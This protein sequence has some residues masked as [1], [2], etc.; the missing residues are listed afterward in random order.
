MSNPINV[1][2]NSA[3]SDLIIDSIE[4]MCSLWPDSLR[5]V[6]GFD[7]YLLGTE[8]GR[9]VFFKA[10]GFEEA[11]PA[12][13]NSGF[14]TILIALDNTDGLPQRK[15]EEAKRAGARVTMTKRR[16]LESDLSFPAERYH[17]TLLNREYKDS[18]A[19]LTCGLFDLLGTGFP[20]DKLTASVAPG[21]IFI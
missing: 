12:K 7:D 1:V 15:I 10:M 5:F 8:D 16:H 4:V 20:R 17:M 9:S 19:T 13:D 6:A 2:Y 11:M 14:Q 3:G 21:L 18:L